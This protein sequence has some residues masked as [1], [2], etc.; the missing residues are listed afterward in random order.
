M[1][2]IQIIGNM[3]RLKIQSTS[4]LITNSS[5]EV[6]VVKTGMYSV[7]EISELIQVVGE[8]CASAFDEVEEAN[9]KK[10]WR[11]LEKE[12]LDG[13]SGM[14]RELEVRTWKEVYERIKEWFGNYTLEDFL[15]EEGLKE[16][17]LN[18]Y[19]WIDI[20]HSRRGT[21]KYILENLEIIRHD[22]C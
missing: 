11:Q 16:E 6:F 2:T 17:E 20:D 3:L 13:W 8:M 15:K 4:D 21:I 12:E 1:L 14:G 10:D 18:Q 9:F 5:S 22:L 7:A 19:V